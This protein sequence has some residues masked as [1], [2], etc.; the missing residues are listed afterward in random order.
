MFKTELLARRMVLHM[1]AVDFVCYFPASLRN[2]DYVLA[3]K[4]LS[5]VDVS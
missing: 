3:F 5:S 2:F 4:L 1:Y